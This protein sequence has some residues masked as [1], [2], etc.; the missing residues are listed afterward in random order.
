[1]N[2]TKQKNNYSYNTQL[3]PFHIF[4]DKT[5]T[6]CFI[7]S[8]SVIILNLSSLTKEIIGPTKTLLL[9]GVSLF[10]LSYTLYIN[11]IETNNLIKNVPD[12]FNNKE[13]NGLK[14]N[15]ICSY[16]LSLMILI[17]IL[18]GSITLIF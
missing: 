17:L 16:L 13:L 1:M 18:Y 15:V 4:S 10:L 5:K 14:N 12:I 8:I 7:L 11:F 9:K 6:V 2:T 3:Y